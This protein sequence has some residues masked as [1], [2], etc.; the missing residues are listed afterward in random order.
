MCS[1]MTQSVLR[2]HQQTQCWHPHPLLGL[3]I[4]RLVWTQT[5]LLL[6]DQLVTYRV[7]RL[8]NKNTGHGTSLVVQ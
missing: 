1:A 7:A 6:K 5:L 4:E 2:D 3:P 8:A